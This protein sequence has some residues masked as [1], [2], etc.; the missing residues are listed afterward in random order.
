MLRR[1]AVEDNACQAKKGSVPS[2]A[3]LASAGQLRSPEK[4]SSPDGQRGCLEC[5]DMQR[6]NCEGSSP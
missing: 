6:S 4:G 1:Y 5:L 3:G 2:C